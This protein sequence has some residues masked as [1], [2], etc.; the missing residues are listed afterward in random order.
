M[1]SSLNSNYKIPE[2]YAYIE[3]FSTEFDLLI[4]SKEAKTSEQYTNTYDPKDV[5]FG[6]EIK[7][8]GVYGGREELK[9]AI[10]RIRSNFQEVK[11][12]FPH[13]NFLYF[14]FEEV[15]APK[16]KTSI[17]YLSETIN[18]LNPYEVFCLRD[19]RDPDR[20]NEGEWS[21]LVDYANN[22]LEK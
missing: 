16:R 10:E 9:K 18:R 1:E 13:I 11:N 3:G 17:N 20:I 2:P 8:H 19:S 5:K 6:I 12:S 21:K 15:I 22:T 14:T 7:A 4:V